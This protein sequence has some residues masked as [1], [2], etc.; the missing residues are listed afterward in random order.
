MYEK[1]VDGQPGNAFCQGAVIG[2]GKLIDT[3]QFF[4]VLLDAIG[5]WGASKPSDGLGMRFPQYSYF[6]MVQ[7]SY[8]LLR[9]KLN[10]ARIKLATGG[11][12]WAD[13]SVMSGPC[14]ILNSSMPSCP[15]PPTRRP[16]T[17]PA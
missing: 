15:L 8:R 9:D 3:D 11:A 6:D 5:L 14:C 2:P 10:L 7:A 12:P 13:R 1:W 16:T 4:V 17:L